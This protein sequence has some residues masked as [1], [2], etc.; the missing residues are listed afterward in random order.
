L[1]TAKHSSWCVLS[2]E[3]HRVKC[4]PLEINSLVMTTL[5]RENNT[6]EKGR[7]EKE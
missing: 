4:Q 1:K 5:D 2:G 7:G 6:V 3:K